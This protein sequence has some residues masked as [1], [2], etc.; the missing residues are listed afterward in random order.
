MPER[1]QFGAL[2]RLPSGRY[3]AHYI[4]PD[5]AKHTAPRTFDAKIDAETWLSDRRREISR[6]EWTGLAAKREAVTFINYAETWLTDRD[7]RPRTRALYRSLLDRLILPTFGSLTLRAITPTLVRQWHGAVGSGQPTQRAHAYGLLRA[8]LSTAVTDGELPANPCHIR[9]AGTSRRVHK[10][11]PLTLDELGRLVEAMPARYRAMTLLSA[12]CALRFG[13]LTALRRND[14][15]L[16]N[17]T[18]HVRRGVAWVEGKPI[19]GAPKTA[20]GIRDVAIPPH[21]LPMLR[22][23]LASEHAAWGRDGLL[24]PAVNGGP[25]RSS[26]LQ[27]VYYPARQVAGRPD[28]RWHDLRHTG[29]VLAASTGATLAELMGRLGHSS[30]GAALRYQHAAEGRDAQ[31]ARRLSELAQQVAP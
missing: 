1:R 3:Q 27:R 26:S 20:A 25:L 18:I 12:W 8:I 7:L 24:F 28:L 21:L 13:E 4:G 23:H 19:F 31:I 11:K 30:P 9:G 10:I 22:D 17:G 16:K 29:A 15:D 6:G 2:R 14:I 5:G